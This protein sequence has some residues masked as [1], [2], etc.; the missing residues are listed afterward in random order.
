MTVVFESV[1]CSLRVRDREE[2]EDSLNESPSVVAGS[3]QDH[4]NDYG[5]PLHSQNSSLAVEV[6]RSEL[7]TTETH[8]SRDLT[9]S[10]RLS[11]V[12]SFSTLMLFHKGLDSSLGSLGKFGFAFR[13]GHRAWLARV[14]DIALVIVLSAS[15][16]VALNDS[17]KVLTVE[18]LFVGLSSNVSH[19]LTEITLVSSMSAI[20]RSPRLEVRLLSSR[21]IGS[22]ALRLM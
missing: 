22:L 7:G 4:K 17:I 2:D 12:V 21:G 11:I 5:V 13:T 8:V 19:L 1:N 15:A 18:T 14:T 6:L 20:I 16:G 3:N 10:R 9:V